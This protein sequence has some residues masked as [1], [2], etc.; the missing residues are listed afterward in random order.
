MEYRTK[1]PVII[2]EENDDIE[3]GFTKVNLEFTQ[4][5]NDLEAMFTPGGHTHL[6]TDISNLPT[7]GY[8]PI[9]GIVMYSGYVENLPAAWKFCDG[10]N[11]TPDLRDKFIVC[12]KTAA[13]GSYPQG[14]TGG[15]ATHVLTAGEMPAHSHTMWSRY[16]Q[17]TELWGNYGKC[18]DDTSSPITNRMGGI[19]GPVGDGTA[20]NNIPPYYALAFI[21]RQS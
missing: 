2:E 3:T 12:C 4:I 6:A 5:F 17:P 21:Q 15:E 19:T 10:A 1:Y 7:G 8:V 9:G 11:G 18:D 20:H 13:G 16:P 14:Q